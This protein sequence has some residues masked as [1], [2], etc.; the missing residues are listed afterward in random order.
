MALRRETVGGQI[1]ERLRGDILFGRIQPGE[2]LSQ[3]SLC[4]RFETS[5]MP[6][7]D[8]L[9]QLTHEGFL[10]RINGNRL[11]VTRMDR[12]DLLDMFWLEAT[13]HAFATKRATD[14]HQ[15]AP[16]KFAGLRI[17]QEEMEAC[18]QS[19]DYVKASEI[20]R[21]FHRTINYMAESPKLLST[22][23]N[24]SLAIQGEFINEVHESLG[25]I[26]AE[27]RAIID[28]MEKGDGE[29][30]G[31]LM[32]AHVQGAATRIADDLTSRASSPDDQS[33]VGIL[34]ALAAALRSRDDAPTG[35]QV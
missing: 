27:Y 35:Q 6:V 8:A 2:V 15:G 4:Q 18:A 23:R 25:P 32:F 34:P 10:E 31:E 13:V 26:V 3:E 28:A 1:T 30:A 16:E 33:S 7:R 24:I 22:L 20:N 14:H 17:M 19:R 9:R 12:I 29:L 21:L 5:R 11:R